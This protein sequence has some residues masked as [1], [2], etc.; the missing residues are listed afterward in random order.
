MQERINIPGIWLYFI[1][2]FLEHL[3]TWEWYSYEIKAQY[4]TEVIEVKEI[5]GGDGLDE[6]PLFI[7]TVDQDGG[8]IPDNVVNK[9]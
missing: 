5:C 2:K 1:V 9:P 4:V 3:L 8:A 7:T 6:S